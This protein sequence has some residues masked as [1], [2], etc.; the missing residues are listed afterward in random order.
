[1]VRFLIAAS[2]MALPLR[3]M[4]TAFLTIPTSP[5]AMGLGG[6][7]PAV[8]G[9]PSLYAGNPATMA[10]VTGNSPRVQWSYHDWIGGVSGLAVLATFP[11]DRGAFALALRQFGTN[12]LELRGDRPTD[13]PLARFG[14]HG[15]AVEGVWGRHAGAVLV[16]ASARWV[17]MD[18]YVDASSGGAVDLGALWVRS[19]TRLSAG[20][21]ATNLGVMGPL[22]DER[23]ALPASLIIG[24]TW[25]PPG[26][27]RFPSMVTASMEASRPHGT[28]ARLGGQ[29]T[30]GVL[31][32]LL[33]SRWSN[34]VTGA[35]LGVV[36]RGTRVEAAYAVEA[37]SHQLGL[38][39][40]F[41]LALVLP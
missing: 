1:M 27:P 40:L 34:E 5:L 17:R 36:F 41:H 16:G 23:P 24:G 7:S 4:G 37:A 12:T 33:G 10:A 14:A 25:K 18:A 28:V 9:E 22:R 2:L 38:P 13:D 26:D 35:S 15:L 20:A 31:S 11:R 29:V 6:L 30:F 32:V 3:G 19:D 39:H 8:A 21:A